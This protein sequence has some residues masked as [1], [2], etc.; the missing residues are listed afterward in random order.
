MNGQP[1]TVNELWQQVLASRAAQAPVVRAVAPSIAEVAQSAP[2]ATAP[3][4]VS[5]E[6]MARASATPAEVVSAPSTAAPAGP[7]TVGDLVNAY[8]AHASQPHAE[9][10]A[11]V[12]SQAD[13]DEA[14]YRARQAASYLPKDKRDAA[15]AAAPA[16]PAGT[17]GNK[18]SGD[19]STPS[20]PSGAPGINW[21]QLG[22]G[23]T[24]IAAHEQPVVSAARQ[25]QLTGAIRTEGAAIE[26][27]KDAAAETAAA[28]ADVDSARAQGL[29]D[30][31]VATKAAADAAHL[32]TE[33][34]K[35]DAKTFRAH[36]D[37]FSQKLAEDKIDPK[38]RK[39]VV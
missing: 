31:A 39:S 10:A 28:T 33:M 26:G 22:G 7:K 12:A 37:D 4:A 1:R 18:Y 23:T 13:A 29:R 20:A 6:A 5:P 11:P 3:I 17:P 27:Q 15:A 38:D 35:S 14:A 34:A 19:G 2:S 9:A 36:I 16:A 8:I 30:Q 21:G 25:A 24:T 32:R